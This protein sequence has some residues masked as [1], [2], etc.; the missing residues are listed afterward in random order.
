[1]N[2]GQVNYNAAYNCYKELYLQNRDEFTRFMCLKSTLGLLNYDLYN[3][4]D[5]NHFRKK[6]RLYLEALG[7]I[8]N[9]QE[10]TWLFN[11]FVK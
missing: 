2:Q 3:R 10:F 7:L 4:Y 9:F 6:I 11:V 8:R 1:M 5:G